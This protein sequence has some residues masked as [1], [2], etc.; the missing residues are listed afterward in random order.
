VECSIRD[1]MSGFSD[2]VVIHHNK[3]NSLSRRKVE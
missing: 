2:I 1:P 3:T